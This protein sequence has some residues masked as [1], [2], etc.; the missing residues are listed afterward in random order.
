MFTNGGILG[1]AGAGG[2]G[3]GDY[4]SVT[5]IARFNDPTNNYNGT[6]HVWTASN[7]ASL[8]LEDAGANDPIGVDGANRLE[9]GASDSLRFNS[10]LAT[11]CS[12][13]DAITLIFGMQADASGLQRLRIYADFSHQ[14]QFMVQSGSLKGES[15]RPTYK[16]VTGGTPGT[17]F[18]VGRCMVV[19]DGSLT[20]QLEDNTAVSTSGVGAN[21]TGTVDN[22]QSYFESAN[23][24]CHLAYIEILEGEMSDDD[25]ATHLATITD[26]ADYGCAGYT[27]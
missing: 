24:G 3:G 19:K 26:N 18:F 12:G 10:A 21:D 22:A 6:S 23:S 13:L 4:E 1:A 7:D 25:W 14:Q 17:N 8:A 27:P 20:V 16:A 9:F 15:R 2:G 11:A 5:L